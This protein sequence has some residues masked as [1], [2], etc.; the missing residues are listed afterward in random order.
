MAFIE[1]SLI[2]T[3]VA[4]NQKGFGNRLK[5]CSV[6]NDH[7]WSI[8]RLVSNTDS[9][10]DEAGENKICLMFRAYVHLYYRDSCV[11]NCGMKVIFAP[12]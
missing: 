4:Y 5:D 2:P 9:V 8:C 7:F 11:I 6:V 3:I 12:D 1:I 10:E